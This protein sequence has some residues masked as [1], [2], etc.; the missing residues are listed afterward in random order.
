MLMVLHVAVSWVQ[1]LLW[2]VLRSIW[3]VEVDMAEWL[4]G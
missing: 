3:N 4:R 1:N 2:M